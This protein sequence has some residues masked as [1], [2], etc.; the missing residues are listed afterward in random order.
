MNLLTL[1]IVAAGVSAIPGLYRLLIGPTQADRVI[2]LELLF[3]I[4]VIFCLLAALKSMNTA[5]LDVS[6]GLALTGFVATLS[7]ARFIQQGTS[8]EE[9]GF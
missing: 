8:A 9:E 7:W 2:G 4:G 3:A 1:F 6:I 5:Y